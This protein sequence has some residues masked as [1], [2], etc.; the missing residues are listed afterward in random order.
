ME[1]HSSLQVLISGIVSGLIL[2]QSVFVA[3]TVFMTLVK[4][5]RAPF[6]RSIFPKL[7]KTIMVLGL[8]FLIITFMRT[9]ESM[10][11]YLV[12]TCTFLSGFICNAI[13]PATNKA[14]DEG[15][16]KMFSFLHRLSVLLTITTLLLNLSWIFI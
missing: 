6:L 1:M 11:I 8:I 2:F 7:F 5:S 4:E 13:V 10:F 14:R 16:G 12:G 9:P 15:H 3:P